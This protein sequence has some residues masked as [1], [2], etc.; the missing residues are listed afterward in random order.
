MASCRSCL[1]KMSE[2]EAEED[3]AIDVAV[4]V[5]VNV[6]VDGWCI[7]KL[8]YDCASDTKAT[9]IATES[10]SS[11]FNWK[12]LRGLVKVQQQQQLPLLHQQQQQPHQSNVVKCS[13][14]V[15]VVAFNLLARCSQLHHAKATTTTTTTSAATTLTTT[16]TTMM[17]MMATGLALALVSTS[18]LASAFLGYFLKQATA[19]ACLVAFLASQK[20]RTVALYSQNL[21]AIIQ[22]LQS[23]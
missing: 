1:H 6:N 21:L 12:L 17:M 10:C 20:R 16:I 15:A 14:Y 18:A 3:L 8:P 11:C 5:D 4:N 23:R 2:E 19:F 22:I 9:A 7:Q 13:S